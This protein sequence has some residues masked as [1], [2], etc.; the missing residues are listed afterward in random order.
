M[1]KEYLSR[2]GVTYTEHDVA[3][4]PAKAKEL[5]EKSGTMVVPVITIDGEV[6]IGFDKAKM[7]ALLAK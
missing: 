3:Q 6:V 1:A 4:D 2:K 7:D 5:I